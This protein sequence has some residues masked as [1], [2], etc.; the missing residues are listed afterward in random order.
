MDSCQGALGGCSPCLWPAVLNLAA[1]LPPQGGGVH[2]IAV[3]LKHWRAAG[4]ALRTHLSFDAELGLR[5]PAGVCARELSPQVLGMVL[6]AA[7]YCASARWNG[8]WVINCV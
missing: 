4:R 6:R 2:G 1:L 5:L 3:C 7:L 8:F